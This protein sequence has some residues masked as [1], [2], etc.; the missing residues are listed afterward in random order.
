MSSIRVGFPTHG[1]SFRIGIVDLMAISARR[2]AQ[3]QFSRL[4]TMAADDNRQNITIDVVDLD[5]TDSWPHEAGTRAD[6]DRISSFDAVVVTGAEPLLDGSGDPSYALVERILEVTSR[7]AV[8][9]MFSC[10]AAHAAL[11]HLHGL[12]RH[13]LTDKL[14]G[15]MPHDVIAGSGPLVTNLPHE[16]PLPHSRWHT[17]P[18]AE[19]RSV[20]LLPMMTLSDSTE[21]GMA[22]SPDGVRY[23]FL[24]A[25]P[26]YFADTLFREYR[27]DVRR[28]LG[29]TSQRYPNL[30]IGY[31]TED[32]S[33]SL[34][35]FSKF[36]QRREA[37]RPEDELPQPDVHADISTSWARQAHT[38]AANWTTRIT[39][40]VNV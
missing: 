29:G 7:R 20:S 18:T 13:R 37:M 11:H 15:V 9:V 31:L 24:Q 22:T 1:D 35:A 17:I 26:E 28:F 36:A 21:W 10:L 32:Y 16:V 2:R 25:H 3:A 4:I 8:S 33:R 5:P 12:P 14:V 40:L 27:R 6:W 30:P 34:E 23:I 38:I 39:G 19:I